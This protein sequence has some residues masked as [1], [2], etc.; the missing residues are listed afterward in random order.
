MQS[1]RHETIY[2]LFTLSPVP[3]QCNRLIGTGSPIF[4]N[5]DNSNINGIYHIQMVKIARDEIL[6]HIQKVATVKCN[7]HRH[8]A[9]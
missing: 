4:F 1:S 5:N 2:C 9:S 8:F 7:D 6:R 3:A